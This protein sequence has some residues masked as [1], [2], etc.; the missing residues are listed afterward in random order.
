MMNAEIWK[1]VPDFNDY[2]VSTYGNVRVKSRY[3]NHS[4]AGFKSLL[5]E[6]YVK[7]TDNGYGY[8]I[9]TMH[10]DGK[11]Q[12]RYVHRLV[13][14]AFIEN[15]NGYNTINHK[16]FNKYN[17]HVE[18]LEW[19]TQKYNVNY[20]SDRM[21]KPKSIVKPSVRTNEKYIIYRK[22][23]N[24]YVVKILGKSYGSYKTLNEAV[25]RRNEVVNDLN[26]V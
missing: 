15:P 11:R 1:D 23:R 5:K 22:E 16:D 7:Q 17:N 2:Q 9:V 18:N 21:S 6:H 24:R 20:S 8:L 4:H 26:Y 14:Q 3:K 19:C 12:N 10:Y 13:A 25:A